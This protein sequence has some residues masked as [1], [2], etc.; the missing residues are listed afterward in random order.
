MFKQ[1]FRVA[2][3]TLVWKQY[4]HVIV[5][6]LLLFAFLFLVGK[7]HT[8]FLI[9]AEQAGDKSGLGLSFIYKWLALAA[10]VGL[11]FAYHFMR[12]RQNSREANDQTRKKSKKKGLLRKE[13]KGVEESD[14]D[15]PF[16]KIRSRKKLRSRADF[17]MD[18]DSEK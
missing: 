8:D 4:K 17:L 11:Y 14:G 10:A 12:T 3:A 7:I 16:D 9:H 2:F 13:V 18:N 1:V 5:S 15:D 6:T